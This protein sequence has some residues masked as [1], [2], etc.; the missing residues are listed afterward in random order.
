MKKTFALIL[1]AFMLSSTLLACSNADGTNDTTRSADT[2]APDVS[3]TTAAPETEPEF[4]PD[5]LADDIN[6]NNEV[7]TILYWSDVE[8]QEYFADNATGEPINDAIYTRN[9]TVEERLGVKLNYIDTPG[10]YSNQEKYVSQAEAGILA[11]THEYDIFSSYSMTIGTLAYRRLLINVLDYP[12]IDLEQPWWPDSLI[13]EATI[14]NK[15]YFV[16][17]DISTMMLHMMY[18]TFFNKDILTKYGLEDPYELV[19]NGTWTLNKMIEMCTGVYS[20]LDGDNTKSVNDQYGCE[21]TTINIDG[22]FASS[23]IK[24]VGKDESGTP[25]ISPSFGAKRRSR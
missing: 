6:F 22:Y 11:G 21:V 9:R 8:K 3:V 14:N 2:T 19:Q 1:A 15:L 12:V 24:L 13:S 4:I 18:G 10:N 16:S 23:G 5:R 17:G 7:V 20:D 25:I